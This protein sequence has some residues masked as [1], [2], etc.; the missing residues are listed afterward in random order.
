MKKSL[1]APDAFYKIMCGNTRLLRPYEGTAH[2]ATIKV[3]ANG[4]EGRFIGNAKAN[5]HGVFYVQLRNALE[6]SHL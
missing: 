1:S 2:H 6:I 5:Q 3:L 4:I